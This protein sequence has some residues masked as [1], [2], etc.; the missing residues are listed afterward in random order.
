MSRKR[1]LITGSRTWRDWTV[2]ESA[3]LGQVP[4]YADGQDAVIV[5]GGCPT[6][7]DEIADTIAACMGLPTE[8][9]R[10]DWTRHGRR[11][12]PLRNAHMVS[13]G[14]DVCLAFIRDNS[15]G[16]S[17]CL[18]LARQAGIPAITHREDN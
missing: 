4:G 15:T 17:H 7:A 12:G 5:H 18:W 9:H 14:A 8:I 6:G 13:L 10:A 16:A 3:I 1:I 11:A 2:I